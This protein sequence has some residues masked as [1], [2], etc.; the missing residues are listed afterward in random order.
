MRLTQ[1]TDYSL[2]VLMYCAHADG[3][4]A[5]VTIT[6]IAQAHD[7]SRNHLTKVVMMLAGTGLLKTTRG[8]GG[9]L[10]LLK[11]AGEIVIGEVVRQTENDLALVECFGDNN[12]CRLDQGCRLKA[13]LNRALKKFVAE[14]DAVTLAD[15]VGQGAHRIGI[16]LPVKVIR[17]AAPRRG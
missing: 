16:P 10:K 17:R 13:V 12:T 11:P 5:P 15:V 2:R 14:L 4:E 6:E 3:R 1:W 7:I 9:G 8:R